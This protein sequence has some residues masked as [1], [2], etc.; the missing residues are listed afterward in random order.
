M[1][2]NKCGT[3]YPDNGT[4]PNC[5]EG[6]SFFK[7]AGSLDD[8]MDISAPVYTPPAQKPQYEEIAANNAEEELPVENIPSEPVATPVVEPPVTSAENITYNAAP[9]QNTYTPQPSVPY[10]PAPAKPKYIAHII[11]SAIILI[12]MLFVPMITNGGLIPDKNAISLAEIFENLDNTSDETAVMILMLLASTVLSSVLLL[13]SCLKKK[14]LCIIS[15]I[16]GFVTLITVPIIRIMYVSKYVSDSD[17]I[18]RML[19]DAD[20]AM[21]TIAFWAVAILYIVHFIISC[22]TRNRK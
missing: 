5:S 9:P 17:I 21:F 4:C 18:V 7:P 8:S 6:N 13:G 10:T 12:L 16:I 3:T 2:C 20:Y 19:F 1:V 14:V 22:S 11:I 15:S